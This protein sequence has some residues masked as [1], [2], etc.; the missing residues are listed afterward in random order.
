MGQDVFDTT[1]YLLTSWCIE[2]DVG[3]LTQEACDRQGNDLLNAHR[4]DYLDDFSE[5]LMS[6]I[7][8]LY[9]LSGKN[10]D[11]PSE[12]RVFLALHE[13]AM[14]I[15]PSGK[16]RKRGLLNGTLFARSHPNPSEREKVC[17]RNYVIYRARLDLY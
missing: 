12:A 10:G 6:T 9:E 11:S 7:K 1:A 2:A 8:A 15:E 16:P 5:Q 3:P 4:A 17:L 14:A 13:A